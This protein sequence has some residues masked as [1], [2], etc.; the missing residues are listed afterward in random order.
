MKKKIKFLSKFQ[1]IYNNYY[2][3]LG[4][5]IPINVLQLQVGHFIFGAGVRREDKESVRVTEEEKKDEEEGEEEERR[6]RRIRRKWRKKRRW[7]ERTRRRCG[8]HL[9]SPPFSS[10][11][12]PLLNAAWSVKGGRGGR[13][14]KEPAS[15]RGA[16]KLERV[17]DI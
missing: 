9:C 10:S 1:F 5:K 12:S 6:R 4:K 17:A 15:E 13:K 3:I 14:K 16:V 8:Q 11:S 2:F 7:R